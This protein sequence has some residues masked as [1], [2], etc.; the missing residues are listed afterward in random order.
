M[1][2]P[3]AN[4]RL[5]A[6]LARVPYVDFL[7]MRAELAGDEMTAILPF[8]PHLVGNVM[9]PALHGGVIGAFM[10]MTALAQL[11]IRQG[12][13][14]VPKTIDVTIDYLRPGKAMITYARADVRKIG[15]Q[16]ANVQ[17]E[18]WQE[19]REKPVASLR[20]HFLLSS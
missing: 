9:L 7:G 15:R 14:R 20:G 16:I 18:A 11:S 8:A 10:E 13:A 3:T 4:E 6:F 2:E 1:T 19:A 12:S 5:Q 17:V